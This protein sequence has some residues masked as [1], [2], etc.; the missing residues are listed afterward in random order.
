MIQAGPSRAR[1]ESAAAAGI[2]TMV[3]TKRRRSRGKQLEEEEGAASMTTGC[4]VEPRRWEE[5]GHGALRPAV[6][7]ASPCSVAGGAVSGDAAFCL[8]L[9]VRHAA[10]PAR[11]GGEG[12]D[13]REGKGECNERRR[14]RGR[15]GKRRGWSRSPRVAAAKE[16]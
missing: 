7:R 1:K 3:A 14:K 4:G 13:H 12:G 8:G 6:V 16:P 2:P 15:S 11:T 5:G 9:W 10:G